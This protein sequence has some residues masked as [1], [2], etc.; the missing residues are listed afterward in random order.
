MSNYIDAVAA[1]S[2]VSPADVRRDIEEAI[3]A[4]YSNPDPAVRAY[5]EKIPKEGQNPHA[6]GGYSFYGKAGKERIEVSR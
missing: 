4:G 5:W 6:R 2:G 1:M 3:K